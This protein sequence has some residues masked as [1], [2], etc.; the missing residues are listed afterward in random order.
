[1]VAP[2]ADRAPELGHGSLRLGAG[3]GWS[4]RDG[5]L[6]VLDLRLALHDLGDPP[7]GYPA[8]AQIEF[9]PTRLRL[10][11][12]EERAEVD[13]TWLVRILSLSHFSRFDLKPSW[14][15]KLGAATVRDAGCDAC[16]AGQAELGAGFGQADLLGV[17]DLYAG[18]DTAVEWSPRLAGIRDAEVRAGIGPGGVLRVRLGKRAALLADARWRW[19]PEAQPD[20][21]FDLRATLRV[22][23]ARDASLALEARRTPRSDDVAAVVLGYF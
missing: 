9:A 21:T 19:L 3:G 2:P 12:R 22:H 8:L 11:P 10:A 6:A 20:R 14:R 16:L 5:G 1:V 7:D 17:V 4:S 15:V 18:A 23:L 13:E